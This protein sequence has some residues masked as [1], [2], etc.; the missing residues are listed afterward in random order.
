LMKRV[1]IRVH[2]LTN[3]K[4]EEGARIV[5]DHPGTGSVAMAGGVDT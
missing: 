2:E 4:G 1:I 5:R 3:A